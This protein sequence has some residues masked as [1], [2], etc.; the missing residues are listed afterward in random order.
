MVGNQGEP[1]RLAVL[2]AQRG[3]PSAQPL[4]AMTAYK[5]QTLTAY[6]WSDDASLLGHG[7][8]QDDNR[9]PT[10]AAALQVCAE[11]GEV[12]GSTRLRVVHTV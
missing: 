12:L 7:A 8:S 10:K 3:D 1:A 9:W 5:I 4:T 6:G 2:L 11:L